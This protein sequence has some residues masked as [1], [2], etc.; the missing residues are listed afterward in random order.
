MGLKRCGISLPFKA[1]TYATIAGLLTVEDEP[2]AKDLAN[3]LADAVGKDMAA[4]IRDG[5]SGVAR[6]SLRFLACLSCSAMVSPISVAEYILVLLD[7]A[8][9]ELTQANRSEYGVHCR[10]EFLAEIALNALPWAAPL[11][12]ERAPEELAKILD[13]AR[14]IAEAWKASTWRCVAPATSKRCV[15]VFSE[16]LEATFVLKN[17]DWQCAETIIPRP[18]EE[19]GVELSGGHEILMAPLVIPGHSKLTRYSA[20]RFR[21]FLVNP[22]PEARDL[23]KDMKGGDSKLFTMGLA[24]DRTLMEKHVLRAY[25]VD[26][27]DN[28]SS[29]HVMAAERLLTFPMLNNVDGEIVEGLFSQLCAMPDPNF[30][31]VYYGT[32]FVDLCRVKDS[33][34]PVKLLTAVE[35]M[36]QDA[37]L[38]DPESFDRLTEWFSFHLS[39]FEY[40]WNWSD[41][42]LYADAD[43]VEKFPFRAL[44]CKDVLSRCIRLS[45]YERI[46][47]IVPEEMKYFLPPKPSSGNKSRFDDTVNDSLMSVVTGKDKQ[48]AKVVMERLC[49]LIP[50]RSV[51][52]EPKLQQKAEADANNGRL[53]SLIRAILLAGCKTLSHFD[54][55][56]ERYLALLLQMAEAGGAEARRLVTL[57]VSCFW[58]E[59]HIRQMYVLDKL[60]MRRVIDGLAIIDSVLSEQR[61][62]GQNM[63][64]LDDDELKKNLS[65]SSRWEM[66]RLVMQRARAREN[67]ARTE[68]TAASQAAAAANEG[69][70][71]RAE[72]RLENAKSGTE[73]AKKEIS[74]LLLFSF[75]R[76]FYLCQKLLRK[77]KSSEDDDMEKSEYNQNLPGFDDKPVWFWRCLGMI[78]ELA[79]KH[80]RHLPSIVE[81]LESDTGDAREQHQELWDSFDIIK[82]VD[83]CALLPKVW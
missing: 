43:M 27:V 31:P 71:E 73:R 60:S 66:I 61:A 14:N 55:V 82:E 70:I 19:F 9:H 17:N 2:Y 13:A 15:E 72:A 21:L 37:G 1:P 3:K 10:G 80:P 78:R 5:H 32:L 47:D 59:V 64:A 40:K 34:L 7:A 68:L 53:T 28:F 50:I 30:A 23:Q 20:P 49:T 25:I 4:A 79:R 12:A 62:D 22:K 76:L 44:F 74:E 65:Q 41:W 51:P 54:T 58:S 6:R 24:S 52:P 48:E 42:A 11:L 33:R 8:L 38:F 46:L 81:Q 39:N 16:L 18:Y 57:E 75:R 26:I 69:E 45:Y 36:F 56:A 67:G 35:A 77:D 63:V 83:G 29:N